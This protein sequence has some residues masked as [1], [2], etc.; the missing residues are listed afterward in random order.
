[1][2]MAA[3]PETNTLICGVNSVEEQIEK[4]LNE[5]CRVYMLKEDK[6]L[7]SKT[8]RT[9]TN[10]DL[11][12]YQ[13]VTTLSLDGT[14]L[15]VAGTHDI[16]LLSFP[17]LEPLAASLNIKDAEIYD[18]AFSPDTLVVAT[19]A[20]LLVYALPDA[21]AQK[22][23]TSP[24]VLQHKVPIPHYFDATQKSSYRA[25]RFHPHDSTVLFALLNTIP[26]RA[27]KSK[28]PARQAYMALISLKTGDVIT[29]RKLADKGSTCF[30]ISA[31]GELLAYGTSD[32]TIG[33]MET[34]GLTMLVTVLK[35]HDFPPTTLR[36]NPT[37]S[38]LV[39]GSADNSIRIMSVPSKWSRSVVSRGKLLA[40]AMIAVLLAY[41]FQHLFNELK[42]ISTS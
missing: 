22:P 40:I 5:N 19:S 20:N 8:A 12:D 10:K 30:D 27:Q 36:F 15:A 28:V 31:N 35:A 9:L 41:L 17:S 34:K 2:S 33:I 7:P 42:L 1:M 23:S 6:L 4:G 11:E 37:A 39:S 29:M 13:R 24:L 14:L 32:C 16:S 3:H 18:A 26:Q 38:L 25:V 21:S